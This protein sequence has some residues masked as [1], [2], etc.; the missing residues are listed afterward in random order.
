[1]R[2]VHSEMRSDRVTELKTTRS[3]TENLARFPIRF[4]FIFPLSVCLQCGRPGFNPWFGKISWR[5]KW[6]S[7]PV[8]LWRKSHGQR[9][10][11]GYSPWGRKESD[12]TERLHFG[13]FLTISTVHRL[14]ILFLS[15]LFSWNRYWSQRRTLNMTIY[16]TCLSYCL[17]S[18]SVTLFG[19]LV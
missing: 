6:Q 18:A 13:S 15:F 14:K 2:Q 9:S 12:T 17:P 7:T 1:M 5:R 11:V 3:I 4:N 16:Y 10:L 19:D 8:L